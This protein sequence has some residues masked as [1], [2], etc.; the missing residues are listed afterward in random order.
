MEAFDYLRDSQVKRNESKLK[1]ISIIKKIEETEALQQNKT[2]RLELK[3]LRDQQRVTE[4]DIKSTDQDDQ[5]NP[6]SY[7][8]NDLTVNRALRNCIA[9]LKFLQLL[10]ENHNYNL[11]EILRVQVNEDG[12]LKLNSFDFISTLAKQLESFL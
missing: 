7:I 3:K 4:D 6:S 10:C 5:E 2:T 8:T 11:Q 1:L 9:I 12:K